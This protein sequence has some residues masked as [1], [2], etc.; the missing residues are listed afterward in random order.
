[1]TTPRRCDVCNSIDNVSV[2][3]TF[4]TPTSRRRRYKCDTCNTRWNTN[5]VK[6]NDSGLVLDK[7]SKIDKHLDSIVV[8]I[9][10]VEEMMGEIRKGL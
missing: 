10:Q 9:Q 3:D 1:M 2:I 4:D 6:G 8:Y 7:L 5:E